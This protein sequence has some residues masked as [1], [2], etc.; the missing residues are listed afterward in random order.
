MHSYYALTH[1]CVGSCMYGLSWVR[2]G[3]RTD[4]RYVPKA[5]IVGLVCSVLEGM[6]RHHANEPPTRLP[7]HVPDS[8]P[9]P[10]SYARSNTH[11]VPLCARQV[12]TWLLRWDPRLQHTPHE[13]M[14]VQ[15]PFT[16]RYHEPLVYQV[17]VCTPF[18]CS[19]WSAPPLALAM[20][21]CHGGICELMLMAPC[22]STALS[23][24]KVGGE[25][26]FF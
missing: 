16:N 13:A 12:L 18:H 7:L 25:P 21:L 10:Y 1:V 2:Y 20:C 14:H 6:V 5:V 17:V 22:A 3:E 11:M 15:L 4:L 24:H 23:K 19:V 8:R 26:L 9:S